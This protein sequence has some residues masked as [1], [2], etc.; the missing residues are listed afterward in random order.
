VKKP[1]EPPKAPPPPEPRRELPKPKPRL[2]RGP[3]PAEPQPIAK[4]PPPPQPEAPPP[5]TTEAKVTSAAPPLVLPG[6]TLESTSTGGSFAVA[7]GNTLAGDPGRK[8]REPEQVKPYKAERYAPAAQ[9]SEL[10]SVANRG[11]IDCRKFYPPAALK[12][13][14][15]GDVVLRV[16]IDSDGSIAKVDLVGDPGEGLGEAGVSCMLKQYRWNPGKVNGNAVA[17]TVTFTIHF[18]IN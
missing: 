13:E 11:Q 16:L 2:V 9:V 10:P 18:T 8:G 17:T 7:S 12:R 1:P 3:R 14:V 6:I 4:T 15:E 5:P